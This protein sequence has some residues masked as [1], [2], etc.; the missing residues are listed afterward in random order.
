[1][2]RLEGIVSEL[3]HKQQLQLNPSP[4]PLSQIVTDSPCGGICICNCHRSSTFVSPKWANGLI[5][6]VMLSWCGVLGRSICSERNCQRSQSNM[7]KVFY[8]FPPWFLSRL[9]FIQHQF[10]STNGLKVLI[11]TPRVIPTNCRSLHVA[12]E[13][14]VT[15]MQ[16]LFRE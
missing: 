11:R 10:T 2:E 5:G 9:V 13:G 16:L 7:L 8:Y 3:R 15:T 4:K 6:V 1:M 12:V 14:D